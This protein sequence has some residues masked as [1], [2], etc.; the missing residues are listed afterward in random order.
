MRRIRES[1][2]FKAFAVF[3]AI[4]MLFEIV[5]P[6][7]SYALTGGPG[8]PE[9]SSFEPVA[10]TNM[11]NE[12]TGDF[13][14][15][16]PLMTVPG[17]NGGGYPIN[18][19][20]HSGE[21]P[22]SEAS[23]VGYG[24]TLNPGSISRNKRGF[25]DDWDGKQVTYWNKTPASQTISLGGAIDFEIFS[26]DIPVNLSATL[27]Y[28]NYRGF[29]YNAGIGIQLGKGVVSL[30][31]NISDGEG[32]F[33]L[34]INPGAALNELK[35]SGKNDETQ[36][37][38]QSSEKTG[39]QDKYKADPKLRREDAKAQMNLGSMSLLGS[40]YGIF[41][42]NDVYRSV[43]ATHY[44]GFSVNFTAVILGTLCPLQLGPGYNLFGSY[45]N[46][47]NDEFKDLSTYGY[48]YSSNAGLGI[49]IEDDGEDDMMDYYIEREGNYNKR[50]YYLGIPFNNADIYTVTGEGIGGGFRLYDKKAR[51]FHPNYVNSETIIGSLGLEFEAGLNFGGG[52]DISIGVHN[53]KMGAWKDIQGVEASESTDDTIFCRF[54]NDLGGY[55]SYGDPEG[56]YT[57]DAQQAT[58]EYTNTLVGFRECE[59]DVSDISQTISDDL[60]MPE[61]YGTRTGR[62]S[63]IG[64]N[65]NSKILDQQGNVRYRAYSKESALDAFIDR[66]DTEIADQIGEFS[67]VNEDGQRYNYGLPVFSKNEKNLQ[68]DVTNANIVNNYLAYKNITGD[69]KSKIGEERNAPYTTTYLLTSIVTPDYID[70]TNNGPSNDDLG[71][72]TK[73]T[74]SKMYGGTGGWY[75]WRIPYTGLLYNKNSLSDKFDNTGSVVEG[76]KEV[77]YLS[78]IE[79]HTHKAD[80][81]T[82]QRDDGY[83]AASNPSFNQN[84]DGSKFLKKLDKIMLYVKNNTGTKLLKT[85]NFRYDYSLCDDVPNNITGGGKLTLRKVWFDYEDIYNAKISPYQFE[86]SYP[87]VQY[88]GAYSGLQN[89]GNGLTENPDYEYF[90]IDPWGNYQA[91]GQQRYN[92]LKNWVNQ[93]SEA[94]FDPAAWHLKVIKLPS[95]GEI[96][97]QYEQ[98]DYCYVQDKD[99]HV[100][101][102]LKEVSNDGVLN[103]YYL[104]LSDIGINESDPDYSIKIAKLEDRIENLYHD[105][106]RMY[107]KFL[108][109]LNGLS[110]PDVNDCNAEYITGHAYVR[111]VKTDEHGLFVKLGLNDQLGGFFDLPK[112]VCQDF[113]KTQRAGKLSPPGNCDPTEDDILG[114]T[115]A[116]QLVMNFVNF[117]LTFSFPE[118]TCMKV[119]FPLSYLRMPVIDA[120][121]GGGVRVKRLLMY[122][123]GI[124]T[125]HPCLFGNEYIYKFYDPDKMEYRSSGV[126]TNEPAAIRE[127]NALVTLLPRGQQFFLDKI[128]SGRD[129]KQVEGPLGESIMPAPSVGYTK[130]IVKNIHSGKTG[131]GYTVSEFH[132]AKEYPFIA[133][134]T[135]IENTHK[136]FMMIMTGLI[137]YLV[138]NTWL[139]QGYVFK[140]NNMHGQPKSVSSYSGD[141]S[142]SDIYNPQPEALVSQQN[143]TYYEPDEKI[144]VIKGLTEV[145]AYMPLGQEMDLVFDSRCIRDV[146][147]DA[148]IEF[149]IDAG[150]F[151]TIPVPMASAFPSY[152][153][154]ETELYTHVTTKVI[155]YPAIV[156][157]I[158]SYSDGIYHITENLAFS[159]TT[160]KP[161]KTKTYDGF[162]G[163]VLQNSSINHGFYTT[164]QI[165]ASW[166][167]NNFGLISR[168]EK[169]LIK[170]TTDISMSKEVIN[171]KCYL[172]FTPTT[173]T[174]DVCSL[175]GEFAEGDLVMLSETNNCIYHIGKS[176]GN[177]LEILP[178][179]FNTDPTQS[180]GDPLNVEI[181]RSGFNNRLNETAGAF[182]TYG[183]S[184]ASQPVVN[185]AALQS[186]QPL[187]VALNTILEA[188]GQGVIDQSTQGIPWDQILNPF[189]GEC[190]MPDGYKIIVD[191]SS[192]NSTGTISVVF[193]IQNMVQNPGFIPNVNY[194]SNSCGHYKR[195]F[196]FPEAVPITFV[197]SWHPANSSPQ[198]IIDDDINFAVMNAPGYNNNSSNEALYNELIPLIHGKSYNF[199]YEYCLP[200]QSYNT[201]TLPQ[202]PCQVPETC[203]TFLNNSGEVDKIFVC[204][205]SSTA[206]NPSTSKPA[207]TFQVLFSV[208]NQLALDPIMWQHVDM[209]FIADQSYKYLFLSH[210]N[211]ESVPNNEYCDHSN[212]SDWIQYRNVSIMPLETETCFSQLVKSTEN[213]QGLG[214]FAIDQSSGQLVYYPAGC[215]CN[216]QEVECLRFCNGLYPNVEISQVISSEA[217][218]YNNY[219]PYNETVNPFPTGANVY[220]KG[221]IGKWRQEKTYA[222]R[223]EIEGFDQPYYFGNEYRNYNTGYYVMDLFNWKSPLA[224]DPTKWLNINTIT[225]YSP[226]G[227]ATE[228]KDILG[229]SSTVKF[230]YHGTQ[231]YLTAQNAKYD[232]VM[233]ES[234]ENRYGPISGHFYFEDGVMDYTNDNLIWDNT[235]AHSGISSAKFVSTTNHPTLL[236]YIDPQ[237][238]AELSARG[239]LFKVWVRTDSQIPS[240]IENGLKAELWN[241]NAVVALH[242]TDFL[243]IAQVGKWSLYQAIFPAPPGNYGYYPVINYYP[244]S[245]ENVWIDDIRFQPLNASVNTYV[246]DIN[247]Q[248]LITSFDDQ[249]F[250]LFYQYNAEGKLVRKLKET[251]RGLKMIQETQYN[252]QGSVQQ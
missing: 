246:Y 245:V 223:T 87:T 202:T 201:M 14:Y 118:A 172:C 216:P 155:Q 26:F 78:S 177:K 229:I 151:F 103:K 72:W 21:S 225:K 38:I 89:Y 143:Y 35:E 2:F 149:D 205:S 160:G 95:G 29:G 207:N 37:A 203:S 240:V 1:K 68:V 161:V 158:Q 195:P 23:W 25:P 129:K 162:K 63:Y 111:E 221:V 124:E 4:N 173:T 107:F 27:R 145:P 244:T 49:E 61:I 13:T 97:I 142:L 113:V 119:N 117:L 231:I 125:G 147:N 154:S 75:H 236:A 150:I 242:T 237:Q 251:E 17:P 121:K 235:K 94:S 137:N 156:K 90:C 59:A 46:Q 176:Q 170:S 249:N 185:N 62:S 15:N 166:E 32:S 233:Y 214:R 99:A 230:G 167:Y 218:T 108:Y 189:T 43:Q 114:V 174:G 55:I 39:P 182:T 64:F 52:G 12:F 144:P 102:S 252:S 73:F 112:E 110:V 71:G 191:F 136:D 206:Y 157:S 128:I 93:A 168:N 5:F 18:L 98:D 243:K 179:S 54:A 210:D 193:P 131:T 181:L 208:T 132:T 250:G 127:E 16:L 69:L 228:D 82:S 133:S 77:Y 104:N 199:S 33:S 109:N 152:T 226:D 180:Y 169:K 51:H 88:P 48:M 86:Y 222:Y 187:A 30:G 105:E 22:E 130:V 123:G 220:E 224:N 146:N 106:K 92:S 139:S 116:S 183:L 19:S 159:P 31:Y 24:W 178:V 219:W 204:L 239:L 215:D 120:K 11:V 36:P 122:D 60:Y 194:N 175:M 6:G 196:G 140:L 135:E 45:S 40:N 115:D 7:I 234:F 91:Q 232:H 47:I 238:A 9:F 28:N 53:L 66:E 56:A 248:R 65:T 70:R 41:S 211:I 44:T 96:H 209:E 84:L 165:P 101:V 42:H 190:G 148:N 8:A 83:D 80:F 171:S 163:L 67:I 186:R 188:G 192:Q 3:V 58:I 138:N 20:Y 200:P 212:I 217:R 153:Y 247:S 74:Y 164:S 241:V 134:S 213:T 34:N 79:T 76:E 10:T 184:Y 198:L 227:N 126:A 85:V 57:H 50:D 197:P 81:I 141:F 100:M